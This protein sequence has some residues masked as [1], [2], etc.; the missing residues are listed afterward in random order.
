M[1]NKEAWIGL[2]LQTIMWW[3][4]TITQLLRLKVW[5]CTREKLAKTSIS[6]QATK[7]IKPELL[8]PTPQSFS[9][10]TLLFCWFKLTMLSYSTLLRVSTSLLNMI[11]LEISSLSLS[12]QPMESAQ[13]QRIWLLSSKMLTLEDWNGTLFSSLS[14]LSSLPLWLPLDCIS[15]WRR[16]D[17]TARRFLF[18]QRMKKSMRKS[19]LSR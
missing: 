13:P 4:G 19:D 3:S 1:S 6:L 5:S 8:S 11:P 9:L 10:N 15:E 12:L 14:C 17:K 18:S 16:E 7:S 2:L